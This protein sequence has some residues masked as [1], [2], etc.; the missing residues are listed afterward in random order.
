M[1]FGRCRVRS[2]GLSGGQEVRIRPSGSA[3]KPAA[4]I[5]DAAMAKNLPRGAPRAG[6]KDYRALL[7]KGSSAAGASRAPAA[8]QRR[9]EGPHRRRPRHLEQGPALDVVIVVGVSVCGETLQQPP[10]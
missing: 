2:P 7:G 6:L 9:L 3:R 1:S 8:A 5:F 10:Y 4:S